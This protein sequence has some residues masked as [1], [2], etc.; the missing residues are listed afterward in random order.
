MDNIK[1][2]NAY[3]EN[4]VNTAHE[5]LNNILQLKTQIVVTA[6]A[7]KEKELEV[8][9]LQK[10]LENVRFNEVDN[11]AMREKM[12]Q[13]YEENSSL[14]N[15]SSHVET[16]LS[17][18]REMKKTILEKDAEIEKLS[19]NKKRQSRKTKIIEAENDF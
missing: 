1:F 9:R 5:Y 8:E 19:G 18:V 12:N 11:A 4:A 14:K 10:E 16:L 7:L 2:L 3:T 6:Q 13:L 15:K 17:Q